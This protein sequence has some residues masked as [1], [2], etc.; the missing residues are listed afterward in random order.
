MTKATCT[1]AA[2]AMW[3]LV[4]ALGG[5]GGGA[6]EPAGTPVA[7]GGMTNA[8]GAT[9]QSSDDTAVCQR[10]CSTLIGC[11]VEYDATCAANCVKTPAFVGCA[12]T[13]TTCNTLALCAFQASSA[14]VCGSA[15][16]GYP[17]GAETCGTAA[18]CQG[19]CVGT[20]QPASCQCA[21]NAQMAAGNAINLLINDQCSVARCP[22]E[23]GPTGSG[24]AC[25]TCFQSHC[26]TE[27]A[28]CLTA[29][30]ATGT[31]STGSTSTGTPAAAPLALPVQPTD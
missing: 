26:Q 14:A 4:A 20:N 1:T 30:V 16:A 24:S 17:A 3:A 29:T 18:T 23:C 2:M 31:T 10:A 13:A 11:G 25:L 12:R 21:C 15:P 5:C 28:Q 22:V 6:A 19:L 9:D 7:G 8:T 27:N